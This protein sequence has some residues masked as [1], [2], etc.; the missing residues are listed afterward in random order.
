M[1]AISIVSALASIALAGETETSVKLETSPETTIW[2]G[3]IGDGFRKRT[4]TV[5]F[6]ISRAFGTTEMG[7]KD[8]HDLWF[9]HLQ[10]GLMLSGPLAQDRWFGGN[11]EGTLQLLGA[12]QDNPDSGYLTGVNFG[13]RYHFNTHTPIVPFLAGSIG[14]GATDIGSPDL[15]GTFQFNEEVG[16]GARYFFSRNTALSLEYA[17]LHVS[18]GGIQDP[19]HGITAHMVTLGLSFLF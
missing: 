14:V 2:Q 4:R 9:A 6:K 12:M 11:I 3:E 15:S 13:L 7:S 8:S 16:A 5:E 1:V 18:N 10:G 17:I 19:N